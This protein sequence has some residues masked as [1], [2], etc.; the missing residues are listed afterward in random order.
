MVT[1]RWIYSIS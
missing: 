1:V